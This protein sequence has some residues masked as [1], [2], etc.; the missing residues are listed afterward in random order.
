MSNKKRVNPRKQLIS[1]AEAKK[2]AEKQADEAFGLAIA[3]M[4]STVAE[5]DKYT[6]A[7]IIKLWDRI[8]YKADSITKGYVSLPDIVQALREEYG[9]NVA[10]VKIYSR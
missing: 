10:G 5:D 4:I 9:I 6:D 7:G 1:L 3:I 8:N 2:I